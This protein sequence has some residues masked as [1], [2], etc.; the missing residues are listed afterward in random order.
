MVAER[1]YTGQ[2]VNSPWS[3]QLK[4]P[5]P[6]WLLSRVSVNGFLAVIVRGHWPFWPDAAKWGMIIP[7]RVVPRKLKAFVSGRDAKGGRLFLFPGD[8]RINGPDLSTDPE[9]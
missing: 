4:A 9:I 7:I 3:G 6:L 8:R 5:Q 2:M 1:Q